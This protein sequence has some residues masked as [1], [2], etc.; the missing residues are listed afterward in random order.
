MPSFNS[1]HSFHEMNIIEG[2]STRPHIPDV[3]LQLDG[4]LPIHTRRKRPVPE[5]RKYTTMPGRSYPDDTE[6]DSHDNRSCEGKRYPGR[7]RYYQDRG[8][9]PSDREGNQNRGYLGK[10]GPPDDGEPPDN[11]GPPDDGGPQ[12]LE[13]PQEMK[14]HQDDLE[15]K[16][17][18]DPQDLLDQCAL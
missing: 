5:M 3:M 14:D 2:P 7:K 10:G 8:G 16:D 9:R 11:G 12:M 15:D 17:H 18:K 13:D 1:E 6:S 4:P